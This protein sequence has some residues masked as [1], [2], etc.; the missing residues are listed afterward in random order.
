MGHVLLLEDAPELAK[1]LALFLAAEGHSVTV[2][3]SG[4]E[5]LLL[6][7]RERFD[8]VVA[9]LQVHDLSGRGVWHGVKDL[10]AVPV[11]AMSAGES[12]W[13]QDALAAGASA[14]LTKPFDIDDLL[15]IVHSL[16]R[17]PEGP[18]AVPADVEELSEEDLRRVRALSEEQLDA[19]PFGLVRIDADGIVVG[20]NAFEERRSGRDAPSVLGRAFQDVA[21]CTRVEEFVATIDTIRQDPRLS[22]VLRF[23]FPHRGTT[24]IVSVRM[25]HDTPSGQLWLFVSKRPQ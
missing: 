13:Q 21:P 11:I 10:S 1:A 12:D 16:L 23:V 15:A 18:R 25:F 9:D 17:A 3:E 22:P 2:T 7:A 5:A 4:V 20:F 24:A 8:V 14:C 6:V 19:L